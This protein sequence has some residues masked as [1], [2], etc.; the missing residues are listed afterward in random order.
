MELIFEQSGYLC[1][2]VLL[3]LKKID[4]TIFILF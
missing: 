3:L 1:I 2:L 4:Y